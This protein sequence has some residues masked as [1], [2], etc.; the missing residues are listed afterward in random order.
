MKDLLNIQFCILFRRSLIF[1]RFMD[2]EGI[3]HSKI[4]GNERENRIYK[5]RERNKDWVE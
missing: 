3:K 5:K 2:L 1:V 4:K